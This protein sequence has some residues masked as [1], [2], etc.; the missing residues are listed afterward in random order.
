MGGNSLPVENNIFALTV[1]SEALKDVE[2]FVFFGTLLGLVREGQPVDGDDDVDFYVNHTERKK[3]LN[4]IASLGVTINFSVPPNNT[5]HFVQC[6]GTVKDKLVRADFYF[7]N[8]DLDEENLVE[9]WNFLARPHDPKMALKVPK[10]LVFPLVDR[11]MFG[12]NVRMP[13]NPTALCEF[14]YGENWR[15]P[16][17]KFVDYTVQVSN[18]RSQIQALNN[19]KGS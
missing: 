19:A 8:S 9:K 14:L 15:T 5:E 18:G 17:R 3:V 11:A 10:A 4:V 2:H 12:V 1:F 7:Y 6:H 13:S 16:M